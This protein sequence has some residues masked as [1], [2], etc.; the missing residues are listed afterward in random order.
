MLVAPLGTNMLIGL[1][2]SFFY[3]IL[4]P[5]R[6]ATEYSIAATVG[7]EYSIAL[8]TVTNSR[9]GDFT[10]R[11]VPSAP[12]TVSFVLPAS[13]RTRQI[14][15]DPLDVEVAASGRVAKV[16]FFLGAGF[17]G[18]SSASPFRISASTEG[19]IAD[20]DSR[21][22]AVATDDAGLFG[23]AGNVASN[24]VDQI[25][26]IA[27]RQRPPPND[28]FDLRV[29]LMGDNARVNAN[30]GGASREEGEPA[31]GE[32]S[33]WWSWTAPATKNYIVLA[34][35]DLMSPR[36]S[37]FSGDTLAALSP[38]ASDSSDWCEN[39]SSVFLPAMAG[40]TYALSVGEACEAFGG[41]FTLH[42]LPA[43]TNPQIAEVHLRRAGEVAKGPV[44]DLLAVGMRDINW[45]VESSDDM[46]HWAP[47]DATFPFGWVI[48]GSQWADT[49]RIPL[50]SG[51]LPRFYRLHR[52]P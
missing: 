44:L 42:I 10:L 14:V 9:T 21:L 28:H 52:A 25:R 31:T 20:R 26:F 38:V 15:G 16:D 4:A 40:E 5:N 50:D 2:N 17:I 8:F 33:L 24:E 47:A 23:V 48:G 3:G 27:F 43:D 13:I 51:G 34:R 41:S 18:S 39:I 46:Q 30:N 36:M 37:V 35:G 1:S 49:F 22:F 6:P 7:T 29:P 11:V 19:A 32:Q 12:P 45:T